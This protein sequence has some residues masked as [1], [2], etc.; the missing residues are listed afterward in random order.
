VRPHFSVGRRELTAV[1]ERGLH[2]GV[3]VTFEQGDGKAAFGLGVGGGHARDAAANDCD[4][5]HN[6]GAFKNVKVL[7]TNKPCACLV[8]P[9][10]LEPERFVVH[11]AQCNHLLLRC[12]G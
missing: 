11:R 4:C 8:H 9:L 6:E 5:F 12:A 10:C 1:G 3:A 2:G 7:S